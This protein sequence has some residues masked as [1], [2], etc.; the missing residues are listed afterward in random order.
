M[1]KIYNKDSREGF[2]EVSDESI[3]ACITDIPYGIDYASWDILHRNSNSALG[4]ASPAQKKTKV[5]LKAEGNQRMAGQKQ[6]ESEEKNLWIFI[7]RYYLNF[8]VS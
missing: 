2:F 8:F 6:M 7:V 4:G 5:Y 1:N 3:H